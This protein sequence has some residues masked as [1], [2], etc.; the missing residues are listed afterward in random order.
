VSVRRLKKLSALWALVLALFAITMTPAVGWAET[1][2][3]PARALADG[4]EPPVAAVPADA[5]LAVLAME[6]LS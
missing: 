6:T 3:A 5:P 1:Q 4:A 2:D